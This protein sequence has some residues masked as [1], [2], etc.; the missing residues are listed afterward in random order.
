FLTPSDPA[1]SRTDRLPLPHTLRPSSAPDLHLPAAPSEVSGMRQQ[2][3]FST[4][5]KHRDCHGGM[6]RN[7]KLGRFA[8]PL[9]TK[10]PHHLV[11]KSNYKRLRRPANFARIQELIRKYATKFYIRVEQVS[12][13]SDHVHLLI[14]GKRR[15]R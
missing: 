3:L 11:L 14:R 1:E 6:L 7:K 2:D 5:W 9:S 15:A 4:N 12:I 8:R 13:Q 10:H